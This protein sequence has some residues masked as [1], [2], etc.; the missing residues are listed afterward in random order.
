MFD[1]EFDMKVLLDAI[2]E[3]MHDLKKD[4]VTVQSVGLHRINEEFEKLA[5]AQAEVVTSFEYA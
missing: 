1:D 4:L 5:K 2:N 3:C